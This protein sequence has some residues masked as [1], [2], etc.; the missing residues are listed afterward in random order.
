M[1]TSF[2]EQAILRVRDECSRKIRGINNELLRHGADSAPHAEHTMCT[3]RC[4]GSDQRR[5][6]LDGGGAGASEPGSQFR[7][8]CS[9]HRG[10]K[11]RT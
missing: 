4:A 8:S 7:S 9:E 11:G 6:R 3:H 1:T 10:S 5:E 2:V